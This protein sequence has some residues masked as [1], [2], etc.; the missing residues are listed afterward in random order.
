MTRLPL[1][2]DEEMAPHAAAVIADM[3]ARGAKVPDLYRLLAN[4]PALLQAWTNLA[5]PLRSEDLTPRSLRELLIM[6]TAAL[7]RAQYEWSHH[8]GL[9]I[10]AGVDEE[11]LL[12][13]SNWRQAAGFTPG[14]RAALAFADS[15]VETGKV[16]DNV[17]HD[18]AEHFDAGQLVQLALTVSFYVCVAKVASSFELDLEPG[19]EAI[20]PLPR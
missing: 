1:L 19:Y 12:A 8:W 11:K 13:L 3:N 9:A 15:L 16:P 18:L 17:F 4:A 10:A 14:E 2:R 6:R 20:P 7:T 5:W